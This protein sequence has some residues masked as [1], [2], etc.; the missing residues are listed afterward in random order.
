[1]GLIGTQVRTPPEQKFFGSF[2]S[3]KERFAVISLEVIALE[4]D[5]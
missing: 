5:L 3:E 1:L 4:I 2:S